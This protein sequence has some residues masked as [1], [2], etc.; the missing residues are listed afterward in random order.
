[1]ASTS[2]ETTP[3][4]CTSTTATV[5]GVIAAS[6]LACDRAMR[7]AATSA[8][9]GT[10]PACSTAAAVAKKVLVGTTTSRPATPIVLR[11]ISSAAVPLDTATAWATPWRRAK[12]SSKAL[13]C[14][15]S[16]SEPLRK[17]S[18]TSA[19][20][21]WRSSSENTTLAA[22]TSRSLITSYGSLASARSRGGRQ[23]RT[24]RAPW[25]ELPGCCGP[26]P[27]GPSPWPT[28]KAPFPDPSARSRS[29]ARRTG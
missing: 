12:A 23:A 15:P 19:R 8:K 4:M 26:E 9:R 22:G 17:D 25:P 11:M 16:V 21:A 2:G 24:P 5:A 14:G 6:T 28:G 3:P 7:S 27:P 1:M 10:P 20:T 29:A 18:S 13:V